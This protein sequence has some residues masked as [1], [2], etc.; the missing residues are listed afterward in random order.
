MWRA[1]GP[2]SVHP[3]RRGEHCDIRRDI[4]RAIGSSP[5]ARGTPPS[6]FPLLRLRRFIPAGAGNTRV[7]HPG[8]RRISVHPRR[9]GEHDLRS[10]AVLDINGSSPQARGTR[11]VPNM[12]SADCRFIPAGAGNTRQ[13]FGCTTCAPV[14]PRRRGEHGVQ[15]R[16]RPL[17]GGSSPQARGTLL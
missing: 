2:Q 6:G 13:R 7:V 14:H 3:R 8:S 11:A 17:V 10:I 5:Q 15:R 4:K 9:R 12:D 1:P 16:E